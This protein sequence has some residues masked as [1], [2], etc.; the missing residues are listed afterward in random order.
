M[1]QAAAGATSA[2][3]TPGARVAQRFP[4]AVLASLTYRGQ[5][6]LVIQRDAWAETAA[7]LKSDP[8]LTFDVLM[9][10][11]CVDYL[12]FG[13]SRTSAPTLATPSPLPYYMKPKENTEK[14]ARGVSMDDYRFDVVY[15][16]YSSVHNHRLRVRV[17]LKTAD[18]KIPTLS[19]LWAGANWFEREAWDLFGVVFVGHPNLRRLLLYE[20]FKGHPL[21]KDYPITKR[22]PLIGPLN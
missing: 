8:A 18:V 20:E 16:F 2:A 6:T 5:E 21:R 10:L 17:P 4:E 22:Q 7:F 13:R 11:S 14:W 9:D 19:D 3:L 1:T 12:R 15:H